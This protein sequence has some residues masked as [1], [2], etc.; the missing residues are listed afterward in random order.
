CRGSATLDQVIRLPRPVRGIRFDPLDTVGDF[1]V[2]QLRMQPVSFVEG[3]RLAGGRKWRQWKGILR[4]SD[5][6][7]QTTE[8]DL[9]Y[10]AWRQRHALTEVDRARLRAE[11][12][13]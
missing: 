11:A 1:R 12:T 7:Y 6:A 9:V 8:Q 2:V 4:T 5:A 10:Q 3:L 13:A